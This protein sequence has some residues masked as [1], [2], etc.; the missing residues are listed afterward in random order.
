MHLTRCGTAMSVSHLR[1]L[2]S[3]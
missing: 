1:R 2:N 3:V